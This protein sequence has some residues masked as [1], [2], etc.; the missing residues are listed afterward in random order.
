MST[1]RI[2]FVGLG[3]IGAPMA[4]RLLDW[5][6]GLVVYDVAP[7]PVARLVEQGAQA[8]D[9]LAD[10]AARVG[11]L[12]VMVRDDA[13]VEAVLDEVAPA[14]R[15]GLVVAVHSTLA[16]D[17]PRRLAAAAADRGVRLVDAPVSGGA[18]AAAEGRLAILVGGD[19]D[20]YEACARPFELLGERI[21]HAG[22]V[23]AG[24]RMKLARNLLHFVAFTAV[25]EA[26]RLAEAAGLDLV[27][28]GEVV[29]H[30]D[31]ITGGPGAIMHRDTAAV[32]G[33]D[34]PW[35]AIMEHVAD[36]GHKDLRLA[37]ELADELGV[38]VPLAQRAR[39]DLG[40]ALGLVGEPDPIEEART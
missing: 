30:T 34:D 14:A 3:Q 13:Q 21:V 23:G 39:R 19:A 37:T 11:L 27:E 20:A 6:G 18:V 9:D 8:A 32:L 36:L 2:G 26:Q 10:L 24:T 4:R 38:D 25:G 22:E 1:Q 17:T 28:L 7:E 16:P 29:R 12:C 15:D 33:D 5:P 31:A 40:R 35:R